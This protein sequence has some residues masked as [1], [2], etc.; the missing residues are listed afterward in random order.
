MNGFKQLFS[1]ETASVSL[2]NRKEISFT[3]TNKKVFDLFYKLITRG[4]FLAM[5]A[6][7]LYYVYAFASLYNGGTGFDW[8]LCI[9]SDFVEIMN[10]SL[11]ESPYIVEGSSY[12]PIAIAILYPFALICKDVFARFAYTKLTVDELT[13]EVMLYPEFWVA[14]LLFFFICSVLIILLTSKLFGIKGRENI[15]KLS[16][17]IMLSAPFIY[18]VM[19]GNTI[20][21]AL[22]FLVAFLLLKDSEK[23]VWR[24]ISYV[25]LAFAG[26]IKIYPL[27]FGT[28][29]HIAIS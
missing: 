14:I 19:R 6:V 9:F 27:F 21:F 16:A 29:P 25:C 20:Y 18:T 28:Q 26:A 22:I 1:G 3:D 24:E 13:S 2:G 15:F 10:F 4:T 8:L 23:A 5:L 12:P 11:E 7:I 17:I